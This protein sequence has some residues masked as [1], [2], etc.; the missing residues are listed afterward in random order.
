M[1]PSSGSD[2]AGDG[3]RRAD[4]TRRPRRPAAG[5]DALGTFRSTS[6][7]SIC[8]SE[9]AACPEAM[10]A[11]SRRASSCKFG[12]RGVTESAPVFG[13]DVA[14]SGGDEF[15]VVCAALN[16]AASASQSTISAIWPSASTAPPETGWPSE[17]IAG[18]GR[19]T[20]SRWPTSSSTVRPMRLSWPRTIT[21][22]S[23]SPVAVAA[24]RLGALEQRDHAV[25]EREHP[26]PGDL[27]GRCARRAAASA[28]PGRS[29]SRTAR[30][31][32]RPGGPRR[33][34]AS[35]AGGSGRAC[36]APGIESIRTSPPSSRIFGADR[37]HADAAA[38]DVAGGLSCR[39][40]RGEQELDRALHVDVL[41]ASSSI[42][43]T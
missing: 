20:S 9:V 40:A 43:P 13:V 1:S 39:E 34:P 3:L 37:I 23:C 35:A 17:T 30:R 31:R 22:N 12:K 8:D 16:P 5:R 6:R 26:P 18:S 14:V 28:R 29:G 27:S 42:S 33:S 2:D 36:P 7:P 19:V 32:R 24:E 21:T 4:R 10:F 11:S 25:L 15:M 38:G 41:A